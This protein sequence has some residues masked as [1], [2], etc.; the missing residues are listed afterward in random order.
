MKWDELEVG[1]AYHCQWALLFDSTYRPGILFRDV[2]NVY[3]F[4]YMDCGQQQETIFLYEP[5]TIDFKIGEVADEIKLQ[6]H[7]QSS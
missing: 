1:V 7:P 4:R 6:N 3:R 2:N 5:R